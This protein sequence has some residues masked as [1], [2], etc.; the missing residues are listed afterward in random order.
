[1]YARPAEQKK[2]RTF[3]GYSTTRFPFIHAQEIRSWN[4]F[5]VWYPVCLFKCHVNKNIICIH[6]YLHILNIKEFHTHQIKVVG[7]G[8]GD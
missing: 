4:A 5:L 8:A 1:V 7:I 6:Y 3:D 2:N